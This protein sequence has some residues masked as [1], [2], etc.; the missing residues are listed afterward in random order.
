MRR[1]SMT[2]LLAFDALARHGSASRAAEELRLTRSAVSH[3][4]RHL[5]ERIGTKLVLR[6][7]RG[8]R[9]TPEGALYA[10]RL[11]TALHALTDATHRAREPTV[12]GKLRISCIPSLATRWLA[13]HIGAFRRMHPKADLEISTSNDPSDVYRSDIDIFIRYGSGRWEDRWVR[14]LAQIEFYPVCSPQLLNRSVGLRSPDELQRYD[15]IHVAD[16]ADWARWFAAAKATHINAP[17]GLW[18]ADAHLGLDAA[19]AGHGI[20]LGD[21]VL[22]SEDL[23]TGRLVRLSDTA[24]PAPEAY[25]VIADSAG[26]SHIV[27]RV[28]VDWLCGQ[29]RATRQ[30]R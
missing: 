27:R 14:P 15:L 22:A 20:A 26:M 8:L 13:V 29:M 18:F 6:A 19:A 4:I 12:A 10:Q 30:P 28:F 16:R 1:L 25:Y 5:E 9:L 11:R 3:Q 2:A 23:R 24:I 7:G 17:V 21:D